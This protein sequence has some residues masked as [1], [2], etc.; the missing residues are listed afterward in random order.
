M[1]EEEAKRERIKSIL[2]WRCIDDFDK[3]RSQNKIWLT[4]GVEISDRKAKVLKETFSDIKKKWTKIIKEEFFDKNEKKIEIVGGNYTFF[5][6][7]PAVFKHFRDN[8]PFLGLNLSLLEHS[9]N[10]DLSN[11]TADIVLSGM[12]ENTNIKEFNQQVFK[13]D[14]VYQ[15]LMFDDEAFLASSKQ[16]I[17]EF[18]SR[19]NVLRKHD[20][21]SYVAYESSVT[22]QETKMRYDITPEERDNEIS[23]LNIDFYSMA[24]YLMNDSL[25]IFHVF[26]SDM[27]ISNFLI[28]ENEPIVKM[29]R[30]LLAKKDLRKS[31]LKSVNKSIKEI[32]K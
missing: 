11:S 3:A 8:H 4:G 1:S 12:Y 32:L 25:G 9:E 10:Y 24:Y 26:K 5:F 7:L 2:S 30:V 6:V 22:K 14:Y 31:Y 29:K 28:L 18:K 17:K 16:S 19:E 27:Y 15:R 21:V 20:L 13:N 23:R